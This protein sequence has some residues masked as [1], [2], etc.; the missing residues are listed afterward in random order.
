MPV[1]ELHADDLLRLISPGNGDL[2]RRWAETLRGAGGF[3]AEMEQDGLEAIAIGTLSLLSSALRTGELAPTA[4]RRYVDP[5]PYRHQPLDQFVLAGLLVDRLLRDYLVERA[6]TPEAATAAMARVDPVLAGAIVRVV[7]LRQQRLGAGQLVADIGKLIGRARNARRAFD[8]VS[9]RIAQALNIEVCLLVAFDA[10]TVVLSGASDALDESTLATDHTEERDAFGWLDEVEDD[11]LHGHALDGRGSVLECALHAAGLRYL[12]H[13]SLVTQGRLVG[14]ML[15]AGARSIDSQY[16]EHVDALSPLLAAQLGY[17][18]QTGA[19]QRADAAIDDLFDASPNM[20]VELD[21]LGRILRTNDRFRREIGMPGDVVG[22]PLMWLVHPA[23]GER[24][25]GLWAR[26]ECEDRLHEARVD[27]IAADSRRRALALEAHWIHNE[28]GERT[29]CLVALWNVTDQ[30]MRAEEDKVRIDELSAFAHH[31]AHDLQA[32]LRTIAGFTALLADELPSEVD[33]ELRDYA[34]RAQEAAER[35]GELVQGLLRFAHGTRSEG[36][37]RVV[38]LATLIED[39]R[40]KL[41]ADIDQSGGALIVG[42]DDARLLGDEVTL[43]TLLGNLV[44]NALR[45]AGPAPPR[46]EVG[47]SAADPGWASLYVRD[48]GI[49]IPA[50]DQ[51]RIFGAFVRGATDQPGSGLGLAIVRRIAR[52]HGGDVSVESTLGEGSTFSVRLPTT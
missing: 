4:E 17:V 32:P 40:I 22:M 27:L 13:R 2:V 51:E 41:A 43:A 16:E 49:G 28:A 1:D 45:Y 25:T 18:R 48:N 37:S 50:D 5:P 46:V 38:T 30:V 21:R 29:T 26:L 14:A 34:E 52:A 6:P 12:S 42:A 24:F 15:F 47:V 7:R 36:H 19:L 20:M 9:E 23:W 44:A 31:V 35:A 8:A 39:V 10:T 11:R 3:Y 33:P